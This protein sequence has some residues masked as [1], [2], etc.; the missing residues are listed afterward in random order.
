MVH[1]NLCLAVS[2][3]EV[4][5]E[6]RLSSVLSKCSQRCLLGSHLPIHSCSYLDTF[7]RDMTPKLIPT[8][9]RMVSD[10]PITQ[11][12]ESESQSL[13]FRALHTL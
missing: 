6:D 3:K 10:S 9:R 5:Y 8:L 1:L 4:T 13:A 11:Q 2:P 12:M 7:S